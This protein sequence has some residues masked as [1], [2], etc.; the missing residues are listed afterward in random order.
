M[1][2]LVAMDSFKGSM[3]SDEANA[4]VQLA[5]GAQHKVTTYPI[6]DGG[7]GTVAAFV[8]LL[9]GETVTETIT[10]P[11]GSQI[12]GKYGWIQD[13][14]LAIIEVAEGAGITKVKPETLN[15][16]FHTSFGVGEQ[17]K[18][19]LDKGAQEMII[20]LGGSATVDGGVGLLQALGVKFLDQNGAELDLLPI[21]LNQIKSIDKSQ[22]DPRLYKVK[23]T[24][25]SD[26]SNPLLGE[27]GATYIFG[28]QKG[29]ASQTLAAYEQSLSQYAQLVN[30]I[31]QT[32]C[33]DEPGAGAA[34]GIGFAFYSFFETRFQSGFS[35]LAERGKLAEKIA[36]ADLVI[37]GEGKFDSQSLNGKVPIGI[38]GLAQS[39][40]KPTIVFAGSVEEGLTAMPERN[41]MAIIPIIDQPMDLTQAIKNGPQLLHQAAKRTM[42]L[43]M[44][45]IS[46]NTH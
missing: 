13:E 21:Q 23:I 46:L 32:H 40:H 12:E 15:P 34:G 31:T 22:L 8:Q 45:G 16:Y 11:D 28:P 29:L 1:D 30:T 4:A 9:D 43:I 39:C 25:A 20:G 38:S 6:A 2:V 36:K 5:I 10:G 33:Q 41:I 14:K 18:S 3:T 24:I 37:T 27:Q 35:L 26:V 44:C 42:L 7:E 19:A 17:I